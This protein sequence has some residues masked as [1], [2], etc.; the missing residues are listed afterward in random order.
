M[1]L[2]WCLL[3]IALWNTLF[4]TSGIIFGFPF[5]S[6]PVEVFLV[7]GGPTLSLATAVVGPC[8][9]AY[10]PR[11]VSMCGGFVAGIGYVLLAMTPAN[12]TSMTSY[13]GLALVTF[14]GI[15]PYLSCFSVGVLFDSPERPISAI[16]GIFI[17]S[18]LNW[19]FFAWLGFDRQSI[20][21]AFVAFQ[22]LGML[23][24]FLGTPS[25]PHAPGKM[26]PVH[27]SRFFGQSTSKVDDSLVSPLKGDDASPPVAKSFQEQATSKKFIGIVAW[28]MLNLTWL[29]FFFANVGAQVNDATFC[30]F[31]GYLG[32]GLPAL[33]SPF[34]GAA[35]RQYGAG[36]LTMLTSLL[37]MAMFCLVT[38]GNLWLSYVAL[39]LFGLQRCLTFAIFFSYIPDT[40]GWASYGRLIGLATIFCGI[41]GFINTPIATWTH[42]VPG[43]K[44]VC[45]VGGVVCSSAWECARTNYVL[46]ATMIPLLGYSVWLKKSEAK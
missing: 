1:D 5:L 38:S 36:N 9:D 42:F 45:P 46:A 40:F 10:G 22:A 41:F 24:C 11:L 44:A 7:S 30:S 6:I 17:A 4:C 14:G 3:L 19:E 15:G 18:G 39:V 21:F 28:Y 8:L 33:V 25:R 35:M 13:I 34:A 37:A 12:D 23:L 27:L 29:V 2:K 16:T 26:G 43:D 20:C 31:V 32:N